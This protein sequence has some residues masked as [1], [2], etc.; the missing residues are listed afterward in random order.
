MS[1]ASLP[2]L[3]G[4]MT[5]TERR[6]LRLHSLAT[7]QMTPTARLQNLHPSASAL[8]Q[9]RSSLTVGT[10]PLAESAPQQH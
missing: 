4:R 8:P 6:Q 7:S 10:K 2:E 1:T 5:V 9:P 3:V